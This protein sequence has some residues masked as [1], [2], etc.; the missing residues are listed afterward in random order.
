[1]Y[2]KEQ[3]EAYIAAQDGITKDEWCATQRGFAKAVL[4]D[5]MRFYEEPPKRQ[6][7]FRV[8]GTDGLRLSIAKF[9]TS[10]DFYDAYAKDSVIA[11]RFFDEG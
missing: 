7:L 1:M 8:K 11:I 2:T 10:A 5:F 3:I 9:A 4:D 6:M